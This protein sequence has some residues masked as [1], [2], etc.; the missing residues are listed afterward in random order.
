MGGRGG[1]GGTALTERQYYRLENA[2]QKNDAIQNGLRARARY[3]EYTDI[4]GKV[5]KGETGANVPGGTYRAAYSEQVASY[6]R[7]STSALETERAR[8]KAISD[9]AYQKFTRAA[10]SKSGAQVN[11][12]GNADTQ[13]K[14][15]NQV[16]RRR[17]RNK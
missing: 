2:A 3:Y 4:S 15:I 14:L 16:L 6:S 12:F 1:A 8:L 17:R 7:M 11:L 10:A 5:H 13:I 9:D